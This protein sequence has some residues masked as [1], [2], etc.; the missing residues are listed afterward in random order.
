MKKIIKSTLLL[1]C[2]VALFSACADDNDSNPTLQ[3]PTTFTLN[4]P[5]YSTSV[6]DLATSS[7]IPFTWSQPA[8]GFPVA[9]EYQ[10]QVS[11]DGNFTTNIAD[12]SEE[13]TTADY[14][15]LKNYFTTPNGSIDPTELSNIINKMFGWTEE[16]VPAVAKLFVRASSVTSGASTI[17]SNVVTINVIPNLVVAPTY[18]EFIYEIGNESGWGIS[19]PMFLVD[20]ANGKY[21]SYN[22]LDGG[23]KFKPNENDWVG[24]WGQDPNGAYGDLIVDGEEDCND[25]TKS[26]PN[27]AKPAGFYQINVDIVEMKWNIVPIESVSIIGGFNDWGGDVEMTYNK[28]DGCWEVTTSEV[29]G[30]YKFRA[31][32]AWDINWGGDVNGL[33]QG[34]D[35]LSIDAGTHTFKLYLS[36]EGAHHVTIQ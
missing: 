12:V 5:A 35:N 2:G 30:E 7:S 16:S 15:I 19:Y 32:H 25:P 4:T 18:P 29:S 33:T 6:I 26:F 11:K 36:Y 3:L 24:D 23:F 8:Y 31:N 17:F 34:G 14:A 10:L 13:P 28:A 9:A 27:D 21:Q 22:Y 20:A 1:L